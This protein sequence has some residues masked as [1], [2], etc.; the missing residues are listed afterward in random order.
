MLKSQMA[1]AGTILVWGLLTTWTLLWIINQF[2]RVKLTPEEEALGADYVEHEV[3]HARVR[4][5]FDLV[6]SDKN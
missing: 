4:H 2:V 1:E 5:N 3:D 6:K